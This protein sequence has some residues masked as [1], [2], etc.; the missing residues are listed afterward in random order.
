MYLKYIFKILA[1][2]TT[3]TTTTKKRGN[4]KREENYGLKWNLDGVIEYLEYVG[5][6]R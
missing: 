5:F 4:K 1:T 2:I 6:G 3:T